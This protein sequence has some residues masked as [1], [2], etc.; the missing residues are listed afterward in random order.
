MINARKAA[1]AAAAPAATPDAAAPAAAAPA[2]APAPAKKAAAAAAPKAPAAPA[3]PKAGRKTKAS[4]IASASAYVND[5]P[6]LDEAG[7]PL[8]SS[9]FDAK[10]GAES[11]K[12]DGDAVISANDL[13]KLVAAETK[14]I[15][16][17]QLRANVVKK[18]INA[19]QMTVLNAVGDGKKVKT[20]LATFEG[21]DR[22]ERQAHNPRNPSQKITLPPCRVIKT[23]PTS[24]A[25]AYVKASKK[26][27]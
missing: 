17:T 21:V 15:F 13:A 4:Q 22:K 7:K 20:L 12:S 9:F 16:G 2:A 25:K 19:F 5:T 3:A 18:I 6:R 10:N 27:G 14:H 11:Y 26:V 24:A 23:K 1:T 8:I